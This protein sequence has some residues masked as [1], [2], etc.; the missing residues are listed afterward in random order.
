MDSVT[1]SLGSHVAC[2]TLDLEND[3]YFDEDGYD[4][5]TF[6][7]LDQY[8]ELIS[9]LELPVSVFVVGKTLERFP[10]KVE[11]L[12]SSTDSEFHLHSYGHDLSK[13]YEFREE[14]NR[15]IEVF[16]SHFGQQPGGYRAPQGNIKSAELQQLD[17]MGFDFDSSV[18]PSY[19][20]GVYS[21]LD[22]PLAP[23]RPTGS[24]GLIEYPIGAIPNLRVPLSQSYLKLFGRPYLWFLKRVTLP[25]VVVFDSHLQDF[26]RTASHEQLDV[27]LRQIHKRNLNSSIKLFRS[28]V[29]ILREKGYTFVKLTDV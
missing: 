11:K 22:A 21:N 25:E 15:G 28:L 14:V 24:D 20:P 4:H 6:E 10:D 26:F 1:D 7:F 18:F 29:R 2:I 9:E 3:W 16:E 13:S 12:R 17:E 5:L 27:P 19:R 23:Y 8:I